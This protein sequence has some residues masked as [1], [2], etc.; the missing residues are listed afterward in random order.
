MPV[1][2]IIQRFAAKEAEFKRARDNYTYKQTVRIQEWDPFGERG[3]E[4]FRASEIVFSPEGGRY[5]RV[6]YE[7]PPTLKLISITREDEQDLANI[8]PFVLTTAD[9]PKY[10]IE[11]TGRERL[12]ELDTYVFRV[13]PKQIRKGERYFEGTIWVDDRDLQIVKTHGKAVPDI[14]EGRENLFPRFETYR[15]QIDG[16]FWF[17]TYTRADD[18]L[19]FKSG[20][21]RVRIVIRY[22]DYKQFKATTRIIPVPQ[23]NPRQ[24]PMP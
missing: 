5:E 15:E 4:Y 23:P 21:C 24:P 3:G 19:R 10:D 13:A 9:L 16:K 22:S 17:P 8:Q 20:E 11:Y 2:Q 7:P 1:E 18:V 6:T 12:D 14:R